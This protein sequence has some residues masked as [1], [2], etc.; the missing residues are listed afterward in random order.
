MRQEQTTRRFGIESMNL[1]DSREVQYWTRRL[2]VSRDELV[3]REELAKRLIWGR[4]F[5]SK[6]VLRLQAFGL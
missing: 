3:V 1:N 5:Q 6:L 4:F 2:G